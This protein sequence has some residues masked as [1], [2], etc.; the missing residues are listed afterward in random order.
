MNA[1]YTV[2]LNLDKLDYAMSVD[3]DG[4]KCT[5]RGVPVQ[6]VKTLIWITDTN[7]LVIVDIDIKDGATQTGALKGRLIYNDDTDA[8]LIDGNATVS[9]DE[10]LSLIHVLYRGELKSI[11]CDSGL[12][13]AAKGVVTVNSDNPLTTND[14]HVGISFDKGSILRI[15]VAKTSTDLHFYAYSALCNTIQTTF[16]NGGTATGTFHAFFPGYSAT[17]TTF[18]TKLSADKADLA[19]I[20]CIADPTNTYPGRLTGTIQL[21]GPLS[22]DVLSSLK[23]DGRLEITDGVFARIPLF[24]GLTAWLANNIPGIGT[25]VN[26]SSGNL[27]FVMTNGVVTTHDLVV[28]GSIFSI[29]GDGTFTLP[30]DKLNMSMKVNIFK[31]RSFAGQVSRVVAFPF[32]RMLLDFHLG[33]TSKQPIWSYVSIL[34]RITDSLTPSTTSTE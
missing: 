15:P 32:T 20:L 30:T 31:E 5:Y 2:D 28:E 9:K 10:L 26:Q 16:A 34:E 27:S 1:T 3:V 24:S 22:G 8:L 7:N 17:N 33:G 13:V 25:V 23:G 19:N 29:A 21:S 18:V 4:G 12:R 11:T 6:F 14:L